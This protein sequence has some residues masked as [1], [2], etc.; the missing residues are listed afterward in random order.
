M[1]SEIKTRYYG[2]K[3]NNTVP[4]LKINTH[5]QA[6]YSF[7]LAVILQREKVLSEEGLGQQDFL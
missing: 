2:Y 4:S 1:K 6:G 5:S 7:R 3:K